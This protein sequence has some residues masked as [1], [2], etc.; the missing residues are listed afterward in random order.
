LTYR[1]TGLLQVQL[2]YNSSSSC[3]LNMNYLSC[4]SQTLRQ[5]MASYCFAGKYSYKQCLSK[6]EGRELGIAESEAWCHHKRFS[7]EITG[8]FGGRLN[9]RAI[10]N[11]SKGLGGHWWSSGSC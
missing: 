11:F 4:D 10:P 5:E 9:F 2:H 6:S 3:G 1:I 7:L 8:T